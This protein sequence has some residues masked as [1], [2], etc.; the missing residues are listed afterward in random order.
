MD[1][2]QFDIKVFIVSVM[3]LLLIAA[4]AGATPAGGS[5]GEA[6]RFDTSA[7]LNLQIPQQPGA[8]TFTK[9]TLETGPGVN[10]FL[11]ETTIINSDELVVTI[12]ATGY[13]PANNDYDVNVV[14]EYINQTNI[15]NP[16]TTLDNEILNVSESAQLT[17]EDASVVATYSE[18]DSQKATI[19]WEL[20]YYPELESGPDTS[21]GGIVNTLR[22]I[23]SWI[24]YFVDLIAF[25]FSAIFDGLI[26]LTTIT[27][28]GV[29][30]MFNIV[31]WITG[32]YSG[33]ITNVPVWASPFVAL[34]T[35][36]V[37]FELLKMLLVIAEITW[38]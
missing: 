25:A 24:G 5:F 20:E 19:D 9:G 4:T 28:D 37:G 17:S 14:F 10:D 1:F 36:I 2:T 26:F 22:N 15:S 13:N 29:S 33:I 6:P 38:I 23:A 16:E 7:Q 18:N 35:L 21:G 12:T 30:F 8:E 34:P 11:Q 31:T 3:A 27:A 32:G